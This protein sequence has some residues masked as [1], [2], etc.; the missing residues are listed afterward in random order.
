[1][2]VAE[3]TA[4]N[5]KLSIKEIQDFQTHTSGSISDQAARQ[6][7]LSVFKSVLSVQSMGC[8]GVWEQLMAAGA[9]EKDVKKI[10]QVRQCGNWKQGTR[11][12]NLVPRRIVSRA[13]WC[14]RTKSSPMEYPHLYSAKWTTEGQEAFKRSLSNAITEKRRMAKKCKQEGEGL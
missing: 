13:K 1:M 7:V 14:A 9:T 8:H 3:Q 5:A 11:P 6:T 12:L 4:E 2:L 10:S